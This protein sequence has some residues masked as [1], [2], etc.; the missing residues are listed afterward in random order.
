MLSFGQVVTFETGTAQ[1][2]IVEVSSGDVLATQEV[3]A[4]APTVSG[5]ALQGAPSPVTGTVTLAWN[6]SDADGDPLLFDIH[7]SGDGG[8]TWSKPEFIEENDG[9]WGQAPSGYGSIGEVE[10][11]VLAVIYDVYKDGDRMVKMRRYRAEVGG[12]Q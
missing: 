3:S 5:V 9:P 4:N 8:A 2:Q 11:G 6:A 10:P 12:E 1:V 7:Y